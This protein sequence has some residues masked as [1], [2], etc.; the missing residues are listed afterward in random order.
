MRCN[1]SGEAPEES[2]V[3]NPESLNT[4]TARDVAATTGTTF[5][6]RITKSASGTIVETCR[7]V[8]I[9]EN[10]FP[11]LRKSAINFFVSKLQIRAASVFLTSPQNR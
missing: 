8:F 4:S 7:A 5:V 11:E 6:I 3:G 10:I 2:T 9:I 1:C